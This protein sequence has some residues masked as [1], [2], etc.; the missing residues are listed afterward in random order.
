[1]PR[2]RQRLEWALREACF[3]VEPP[4]LPPPPQRSYSPQQP[5]SSNPEQHGAR[6]EQQQQQALRTSIH[7][8]PLPSLAASLAASAGSDLAG[9]IHATNA[10]LRSQAADSTGQDQDRALQQEQ[11][12]ELLQHKQQLEQQLAAAREDLARDESIFAGQAQELQELRMQLEQAQRQAA[13][14]AQRQ[15]Q[16]LAAAQA[17]AQ[18]WRAQAMQVGPSLPLVAAAPTAA[19]AY[20]APARNNLLHTSTRSRQAVHC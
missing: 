11:Q 10:L 7:S 3:G 9:A 17:E 5:S 8:H 20:H 18:R 14:E 19:L 12:Q 4:P 2:C 15:A 1:M 13:A 16:Q 6:S